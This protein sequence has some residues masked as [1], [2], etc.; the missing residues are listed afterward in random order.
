MTVF[1][2]IA[3]SDNKT[4]GCSYE[5]VEK[6]FARKEDAERYIADRPKPYGHPPSHPF[7]GSW[8]I[9]EMEVE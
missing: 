9:E 2:L 1:L 3:E 4:C 8:R 5:S 6:V 7:H